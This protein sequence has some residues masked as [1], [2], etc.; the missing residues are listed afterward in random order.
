M[1][2][3]ERQMIQAITNRKTWS[4]SNTRVVLWAG[5]PITTDPDHNKEEMRIYLHGNHIASYN[6]KNM[7]LEVNNCGWLTRTTK[8]RL[9]AIIQ[10]VEG[11]LA[12]IYQKRGQWYLKRP[13]QSDVAMN[14]NAWLTV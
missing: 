3:I 1:R 10:F 7:S 2:Q 8:S 11:G 13:N 5:S 14:D 6:T 12:G 4:N 9:N